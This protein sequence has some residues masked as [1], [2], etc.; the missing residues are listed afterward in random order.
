MNIK[1]YCAKTLK[2]LLKNKAVVIFLILFIVLSVTTDNFLSFRNLM[3]ILEQSVAYTIIALGV[4]M[5]VIGSSPDLSVGG[6]MCLAGVVTIGLQPYMSTWAS[7]AIA[8]LI[9]ALIGFINGFFVVHQKTEAWVI[10]LGMGIMI[11]GINLV[12]LEGKTIYGTDPKFIEYG[13]LKILGVPVIVLIAIIFIAVFHYIMSRTSF[14]RNIYAIG[15]DYEVAEYSGINARRQKWLTFV[16]SGITAAIG[17][18]IFT[19][20]VNAASAIFGENTAL[21]VNCS[22]VIGGTSFAGGVGGVFESVTGILLLNI[23]ENGMNL[24]KWGSYIQMLVE[25]LIIAFITTIDLYTTK[26]KKQKV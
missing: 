15:G 25:G 16:I 12:L 3:G 7:A 23:I 19:S 14:G 9:G 17:G 11:R 5:C 1:E 8:I 20:R 22:I 10:T 24:L 26:L 18:I 21:L 2:L 4:T 13:S 6:T